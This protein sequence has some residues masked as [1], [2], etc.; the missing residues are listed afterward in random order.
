MVKSIEDQFQDDMT[1]ETPAD[2]L[3]RIGHGEVIV[4]SQEIGGPPASDQA[5]VIDTSIPEL[6]V[7]EIRTVD[8]LL[9]D[10]A[11]AQG[12]IPNPLTMLADALERGVDVEKLERLFDLAERHEKEVQRKAFARALSDFQGDCPDIVD[13]STAYVNTADG[14]SYSYTYADLDQIMRTIRPTLKACGLSVTYDTQIAEDGNSITSLC[15]IMHRDG[16]TEVRTFVCPLDEK[17]KIND[18]Q[19]MGSA[20]AYA[21]RYNVT[22]ALGLTTGEDDDG[23]GGERSRGAPEPAKAADIDEFF[24]IGKHKGERWDAVPLDY[25][26][27]AVANLSEK[28]DIVERAQAQIDARLDSMDQSPAD[29]GE[30][31]MAECARGMTQAKTLDDLVDVWTLVPDKHRDG[32]AAFHAT[33]ERELG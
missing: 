21:S 25:L 28:P 2:E 23:A 19:K 32:L 11:T 13:K 9:R 30:L 26:E 18:S 20:N 31:T 16:H 27:W 29:D 10:M 24:P 6:E 14:G 22:N 3:A 15:Y 17:L 8:P 4:E 5:L 33:R 12:L 1:L 7:G